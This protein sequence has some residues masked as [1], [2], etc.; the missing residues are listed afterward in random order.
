[1]RKRIH[2]SE[3]RLRILEPIE[4]LRDD[5]TRPVPSHQPGP[6]SPHVHR[7]DKAAVLVELNLHCMPDDLR[8]QLA[9]AV[10]ALVL[11]VEAFFVTEEERLVVFDGVD[12]ERCF[13]PCPECLHFFSF[14]AASISA[15]RLG[16]ELDGLLGQGVLLNQMRRVPDLDGVVNLHHGT[17]P[18]W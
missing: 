15:L 2:K 17:S 3:D 11:F 14:V 10:W 9:C 12:E 1:M 7:V 13:H 4:R 6:V 5:D 8:V 18:G 16:G